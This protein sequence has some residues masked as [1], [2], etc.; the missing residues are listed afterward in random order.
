MMYA[1]DDKSGI[2]DIFRISLKHEGMMADQGALKDLSSYAR[3]LKLNV[4]QFEDCL[5]TGKYRASINNDME[6]AKKL[7]MSGVPGFIIGIVNSK[8]PGKVKGITLILGAQPVSNFQNEIEA[9]IA[10][11]K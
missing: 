5:N 9:A 2:A 7:G 6:L 1:P 11:N 8:K 10:A 3:K 4:G